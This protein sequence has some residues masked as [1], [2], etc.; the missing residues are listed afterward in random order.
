MVEKAKPQ[1]VTNRILRALPERDAQNLLLQGDPV[2]LP[3]K[4]VLHEPGDSSDYV[5]FPNDGV[6]SL[7]TVAAEGAVEIATVGREGMA[8][9]A[10]YLGIDSNARWLVQVPGHAVR[11]KTENFREIVKD[12]ER[13]R[14]VLDS[15]MVGMYT[16]VS[17]TAACNSR[18]SIEARCARWLLM[19]LDRV[20]G[21]TFPMTHD[22]LASMLGTR[23]ASVSI[24]MSMLQQQGL[25]EYSRGHV[26][27]VRQSALAEVACE[28]YSLIREQFEG[29][30]PGSEG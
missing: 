2:D 8:D 1:T 30:F 18:H 11:L 20:S 15:Y 17:Q 6:I 23:R 28:C 25:I 29:L 7:L 14:S 21:D 5:Y 26:H 4:K 27:V 19:T 22:F 9:V 3:M 24:A 16:L 12:S 13:I 10:T